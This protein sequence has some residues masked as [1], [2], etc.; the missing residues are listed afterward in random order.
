MLLAV[1]ALLAACGDSASR[2]EKDFIRGCLDGPVVLSKAQCECMFSE[3]NKR[4]SIKELE[5]IEASR[6]ISPAFLQ[7]ME[8]AG[9][10][11]SSASYQ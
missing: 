3:L 1:S 2:F 7:T 5:E 9:K 10:I 8:H 4:Y 6:R 11:C